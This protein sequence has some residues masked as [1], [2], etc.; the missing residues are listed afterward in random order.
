[1]PRTG[2]ERFVG[3]LVSDEGFVDDLKK[4]FSRAVAG[5][6]IRLSPEENAILRESFEAY[7]RPQ[8]DAP[9]VVGGATAAAPV[10]VAVGAAVA[11]S[12]AGS[13]AT[14]VVDK[15]TDDKITTPVNMRLRD[16]LIHRRILD[17]RVLRGG[18]RGG[19]GRGGF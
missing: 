12:V 9:V 14:K 15:L 6:A 1:M 3:L 4:D 16:S 2:V 17:A 7:V 19:G 8:L 10:A 18:P 5:R 13:I 11:G